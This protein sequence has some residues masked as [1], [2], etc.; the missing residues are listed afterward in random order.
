MLKFK[1]AKLFDASGDPSGDWYVYWFIWESDKWVQKKKRLGMNRIVS[2]SERREYGSQVVKEINKLLKAGNNPFSLN[3]SQRV[4][5]R[6]EMEAIV[7]GKKTSLRRRSWQSYKYS[8]DK[9]LLW[10][11]HHRP[12]IMHMDQMTRVIAREFIESLYACGYNGYTINAHRGFLSAIFN[13]WCNSQ[14]DLIANPF[15]GTRK[16]QLATGRNIAFS[17]RQLKEVWEYLKMHSPGLYLFTR[18]IYFTYIR[19]IELLRLKVS[20]VR[21]DLGQIVIQGHQSK[22]KKQQSVV[23]PD[24]FMK[25]ILSMNLESLPQDYYIFSKLLIPGF[26]SY[27][28]NSVSM[29]HGQ[30]LKS[31]GYKSDLTLYS[32]KHTGVVNAYRNGIDVYAIMRQL[33]H[34]S[35]DQTMIYLKSLGIVKNEEFGKKMV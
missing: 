7:S 17:D 9:F 31:L 25:D 28:R 24:A 12:D 8:S 2:V 4:G 23:I 3:K 16:A 13:H 18:F 14:D 19:P 32:W 29:K 34:H 6:Q 11:E 35:L 27:S 1:P 21:L 15:T 30:A 5:I 22:N 20:D 10:L 26:E 33:R